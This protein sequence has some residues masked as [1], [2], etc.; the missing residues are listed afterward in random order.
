MIRDGVV[1]RI[2]LEKFQHAS[3]LKDEQK[4][5]LLLK[6][7]VTILLTDFGKSLI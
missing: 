6:D 2:L 3:L 5:V 7:V 4:Q 1:V